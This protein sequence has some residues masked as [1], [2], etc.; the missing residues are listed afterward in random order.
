M[1]GSRSSP[2]NLTATIEY[3]HRIDITPDLQGTRTRSYGGQ[4][5]LFSISCRMTNII[6]A[7][8]SL[9]D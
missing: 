9:F 8:I 3:A 1:V 6:L 5:E 2:M 4:I 7:I